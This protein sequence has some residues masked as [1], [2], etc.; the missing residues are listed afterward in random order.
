M[1]ATRRL[2]WLPL[3]VGVVVGALVLFPRA[4]AADTATV[5][6]DGRALF[7]VS[8]TTKDAARDRADEIARRMSALANAGRG[9]AVRIVP[10]GE[11]RRLEVGGTRI[12]TVTTEDADEQVSSVDELARRWAFEIEG[13]LR[14]AAERAHS[15]TR[16]FGANIIASIRAAFGGVFESAVDIIP[17][18][19]AAV[20]VLGFF[21]IVA[22]LVRLAL[23]WIFRRFISDLTVENLL[24]Q[25]GYY[26]VWALGLIV[27]IDALGINKGRFATGLGL[28]GIALG[29]ALKDILSNFVSGLLL[30]ALR[31]FRVG[32]QIVIGD[33]EGT[34]ER[35]ELRATQIRTYDGRVVL[36][37]NAQIFTSRLTNNTAGPVRRA[38]FRVRIGY[39]VDLQPVLDVLLD[40]VR[41]SPG[42][43]DEPAPSVHV[44]DLS[45]DDALVELRF[46]ADS[47]R[48]DF[49]QTIADA[50][51]ELWAAALRAQI[52][53]PDPAVRSIKTQDGEA[54]V[55]HNAAHSSSR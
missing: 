17:R 18:L 47:R 26:T 46:W 12:A 29:F 53:L 39:R 3:V 55:M 1:S 33:S 45:E 20:L 27:A 30:L 16:R 42:V 31:P 52:P 4:T 23:R 32:D 19:I 54:A 2:R 43:L 51:R 10:D 5:R 28:T 44:A 41:R 22:S 8:A 49:V 13:A 35:V 9:A 34:V 7:K 38:S 25:I 6:F 37:P 24:K 14:A 21:W 48:S 50:R 40:A 36:V 15:P 11:K